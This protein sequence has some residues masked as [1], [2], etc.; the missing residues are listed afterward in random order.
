MRLSPKSQTIILTAFVQADQAAKVYLFGSRL[1]DGALGGDID[2]LV[3]SG[4]IDKAQLRKIKWVLI[5]QLGEQKIDV[6]V[7]KNLE[8]P[9]V[10]LIL[11]KAILLNDS[12]EI[13]K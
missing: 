8:E 13:I 3:H 4:V 5:E 2:L 12:K 6:L 10:R 7:S 9:F 11:P 1:D